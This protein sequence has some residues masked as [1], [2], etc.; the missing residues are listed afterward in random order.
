M[1]PLPLSWHCHSNCDRS[2]RTGLSQHPF[3][4]MSGHRTDWKLCHDSRSQHL[5]TDLHA[6]GSS[7]SANQKHQPGAVRQ[8]RQTQRHG[9]RK[10]PSFPRSPAEI[11]HNLVFTIQGYRL[12]RHMVIE[13]TERPTSFCWSFWWTVPKS[14]IYQ[15]I[16]TPSIRKMPLFMSDGL[17]IKTAS[18]EQ[19]KTVR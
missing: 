15:A 7:V 10:G 19:C 3:C 4:R 6:P 12:A 18:A 14:A 17:P 1:W 2:P 5:R 13:I 11:A 16:Y 9:L 8:L